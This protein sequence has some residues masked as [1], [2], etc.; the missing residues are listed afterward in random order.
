MPLTSKGEKIKSSMESEYGPKKGEQVFYAS[1][2]KGTISG[3]DAGES[4]WEVTFIG[5]GPGYP[6]FHKVKVT[7][8]TG[9]EAEEKAREE[10]KI[11]A[12]N[13]K[14]RLSTGMTKN[15]GKAGVAGDA[16]QQTWGVF[17]VSKDWPVHVCDDE[18]AALAKAKLLD[19]G[20]GASV[21]YVEKIGETDIGQK[22]KSQRPV[23]DV[24]DCA[25]EMGDC[26]LTGDEK[27]YTFACDSMVRYGRIVNR[28]GS[29]LLIQGIAEDSGYWFVKGKDTAARFA[30]RPVAEAC[31]K[32][33]AL[34]QDA[35]S[36][37]KKEFSNPFVE[38]EQRAVERERE[39]QKP[40]K[41]QPTPGGLWLDGEDAETTKG[42]E[43]WDP[44]DF[45]GV[46]I[47]KDPKE[48]E[49]KRMAARTGNAGG[50]RGVGDAYES[51]DWGHLDAD[52]QEVKSKGLK[53]K[54]EIY[55]YIAKKH[56]SHGRARAVISRM[57]SQGL[58]AKDSRLAQDDLFYDWKVTLKGARGQK[59]EFNVTARSQ[60]D[61]VDEAKQTAWNWKT[62]GGSEPEVVSVERKKRVSRD[63]VPGHQFDRYKSRP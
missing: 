43:H 58:L 11:K 27:P 62:G 17:T 53:S 7:A 31:M 33:L 22:L 2:N 18:E 48:A 56:D 6:A 54:S 9:A 23:Y 21:H 38:R 40:K 4:N 24:K 51:D 45:T 28:K 8:H 60:S 1:K 19:N 57:E 29:V 50:A 63:M 20:V 46:S 3:V 37:T 41:K 39:A 16:A 55:N 36:D 52:I 5:V 42:M 49:R 25:M 10:A 59:R 15:L 34:A 26:D 32:G 14:W 61:A 44:G 30:K 12:D 35:E 47:P 13:S